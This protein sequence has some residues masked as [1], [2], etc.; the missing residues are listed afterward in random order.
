MLVDLV[1]LRNSIFITSI[2]S[3]YLQNLM[4]QL[5]FTF[6]STSPN[7]ASQ[8]LLQT[9]SEPTPYSPDPL[10]KHKSPTLPILLATDHRPAHIQIQA[11]C[12]SLANPTPTSKTLFLA[13]MMVLFPANA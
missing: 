11:P 12:L 1:G 10:Q 6:S 5:I 7:T 2:L 8:D 13:L 4:F 9:E 3:S